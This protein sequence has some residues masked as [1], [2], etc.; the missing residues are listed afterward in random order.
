LHRV[1]YQVIISNIT[2]LSYSKVYIISLLILS[3]THSFNT[4]K[5]KKQLHSAQPEDLYDLR[6][7]TI[8]SKWRFSCQQIWEISL[9][10]NWFTTY[11]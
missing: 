7:H 5:I 3:K 8:T 2:L 4:S 6:I 9:S 11:I 1:N 10:V